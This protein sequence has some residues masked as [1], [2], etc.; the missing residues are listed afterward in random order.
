MSSSGP[1]LES[2]LRTQADAVL[3]AC[4]LCGRCAE[5]CPVVPS[6]GLEGEEPARIVGGV[7]D[8]LR[9]GTPLSGASAAWAHQCNGCGA[10]IP[11]CPEAVNP[12][13]MLMLANTVDTAR[14]GTATP[15][16]FRK[17]A[18]AIHLMTAM[19][20]LP[21][22]YKRLILPTRRRAVPVVFYLGC[23]ALRTPHLLFN[24]MYVLDALEVD[25]AVVGGPS[26][27]CGIIHSKW[28][29]EIAKGGRVTEGTLSR[30]A[31]YE[32]EKVLSWCPSC[33][34]HLGETLEGYRQSAFSLEHVTQFLTRQGEALTRRFRTPVRRRVILHAHDGF[35]EFGR[36]VAALLEA[37]PGLTVVETVIESGYTCGGSGADRA[38]KLKAEQR[39][40]TIERVRQGDADTLV[41][42]YHVCHAQL[43]AE[44]KAGAVEVLNFTDILVE[45]LG[46]TPHEDVLKRYRLYDDWKMVVDEGQPYLRSNGIDLD[47]DVLQEILPR[48][49]ALEEFKGGLQCF[50]SNAG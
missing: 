49:F 45:A 35:A 36:N 14:G 10:C 20:L 43:V 27:C 5:I 50:G 25:Y 39:A 8:L 18:R 37:I 47:P 28:E 46:G 11:A 40:R 32:P 33:Q 34:L 21:E 17:M 12:R 1:T 22:E 42:L 29:G 16:L 3:D 24:A 7:L 9:L 41:T 48:V 30:F 44:E 19:Q 15:Q 4:T 26:A 2:Y 23:N 13:R 31:D 6:A 38:P